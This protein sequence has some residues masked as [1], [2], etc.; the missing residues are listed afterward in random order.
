MK[1]IKQ[2]HEILKCDD[3]ALIEVCG[4]NCWQ[5]SDK[6]G[7]SMGDGGEN[8][9]VHTN[10]VGI[11]CTQ[12][13]CPNHSSQTFVK[14]LR[15]KK[16]EAMLEFGDIIVR[17]IT[18][19]GVSH[20]LVRHR[21][22][23]FSQESTRYVKL[24]KNMEFI[25]PVWNSTSNYSQTMNWYD[26]VEKAEQGYL[27]ALELG[28][29]PE[30]AREVL[31]NSLKTEIIVKANFREWRNIFNLRCSTKSHPQMVG[32]MRSLLEEVHDRVPVV[33]DDLYEKYFN[34]I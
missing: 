4:R 32:L 17:F 22:C 29:K 7:C 30:Q 33:F 10:G 27:K 28:Q 19:R 12:T 26:S 2:S 14:M 1:I 24:D 21:L 16:H 13:T 34:R 9:L 5:S 15:S 3:I 25:L 18:N 6:I 20:E 11:D 31:P 23:S 8:C